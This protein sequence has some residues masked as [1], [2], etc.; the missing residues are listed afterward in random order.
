MSTC[1]NRNAIIAAERK[2]LSHVGITI[3]LFDDAIYENSFDTPILWC[4]KVAAVGYSL[5][6]T[7]VNWAYKSDILKN[8]FVPVSAHI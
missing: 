8:L 4:K 2:N 5:M 7:Q 1:L 3:F 6:Y